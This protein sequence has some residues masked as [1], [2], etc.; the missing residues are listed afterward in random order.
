MNT[1]APNKISSYK[2]LIVLVSIIIPIVVGVLFS[3]KKI[4]GNLSFLPPIYAGFNAATSILLIAA[5]IAIKNGKT[6]AHRL[7]VR[8]ALLLSILFLGCYVAYHLTSNPTYF[9]DLD[10]NG[11]LSD[12]EKVA[13]GKWRI[14][15]F[16]TLISHIGLSMVV[17]PLVLFSY[18]HAWAG[19]Y[20]KHKQLVR[21][22]YPIWLYVAITGV[23]VYWM[24]S[25]YYV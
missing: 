5:L 3:I 24:I 14:I 11:S 8:L 7:F 10:H 9:G 18:L 2:K 13:A 4:P 1:L 16:F 22:S 15:Y 6:K 19:N 21:F 23:L 17:I 20:Q 12:A 25:P